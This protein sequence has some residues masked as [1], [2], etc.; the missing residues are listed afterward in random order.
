M[1]KALELKALIDSGT[2]VQAPGAPDPLV[3]R[4]VQRAGF[5]AVYM[6]GFGA[7][8]SRLG[9]PDIGLLSQTEM[10]THARDMA[11][12]VDIPIIAD[13]DTGYGGPANI[14]RT[15]EEYIQAG[16]AAIHL[17]DQ[18]LPKRC[19]QRAGVR[20]ISAE[21]NVRRLQCAVESRKQNPLLIIARTDAIQSEGIDE[22]IRRAKLY[23]DAGAD[24]VFV[25][26]IKKIADVE[27]VA[28]HVSGPKVVSIVDGNETI[29]LTAADLQEMGF[30]VVFYALSA[31][32]S[33]VKAVE[34]TLAAMKRDGT[35]KNRQSDMVT[36]AQ[37][38]DLTGLSAY[39]ALDDR[40]G[41]STQ[42]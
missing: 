21:E 27:A 25:D 13:A 19:G 14:M 8:A 20:V 16:V 26:G 35:P 29:A 23:Q 6:T 18:Q 40:Y 38:S 22:A 17:E 1:N 4:L 39:D 31:L 42:R 37:F 24:L 9:L 36:Y 34:D 5:P 33:A 3:A 32:F 12:A 7:T 2:I 15:V 28:K 30:N 11:R 41:W 10:T